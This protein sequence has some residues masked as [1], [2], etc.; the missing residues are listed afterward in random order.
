MRRLGSRR[1]RQAPMSAGCVTKRHTGTATP[2]VLDANVLERLLEAGAAEGTI[3]G[4]IEGS[5]DGE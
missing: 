4:S 5:I 3:E 1:D 2:S